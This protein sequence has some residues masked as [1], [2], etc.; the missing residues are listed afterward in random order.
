MAGLGPFDV[1]D[2]RLWPTST[3]EHVKIDEDEDGFSVWPIWSFMHEFGKYMVMGSLRQVC[4]MRVTI[5][6][7]A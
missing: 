6:R 1:L 5:E 2:W 4:Q 7:V 3:E